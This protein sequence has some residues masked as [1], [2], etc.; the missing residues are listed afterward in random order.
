MLFLLEL[1]L[2]VVILYF[3]RKPL[4]FLF[5]PLK[6]L[7]SLFKNEHKKPVT[8]FNI[9]ITSMKRIGEL[10]VYQIKNRV[11]IAQDRA[12]FEKH[13]TLSKLFSDKKVGI[14][15][16]F[17]LDFVYDLKN[18]DFAMQQTDEKHYL[19]QMPTCEYKYNIKNL[20]IYSEQ[21][22]KFMPSILPGF[23]SGMI[24]TKFSE[25]EKTELINQALESNKVTILKDVER[26]KNEIQTSAQDTIA[27]LASSFGGSEAKVTVEFNDK[28]LLSA[29]ATVYN[30]I[31]DK[32]K[33][34][35]I[36]NIIEAREIKS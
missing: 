12:A 1:I 26:L 13:P 21:N 10:N 11:N 2:I 28:E 35:E 22:S 16:D 20:Q 3:I 31:D 14:S 25:A 24:G 36:S 8:K 27:S 15:F 29:D 30:F 34:D 32:Q 6:K 9:D 19:V 33:S 23:V 17:E 5:A 18:P 7:G 4:A